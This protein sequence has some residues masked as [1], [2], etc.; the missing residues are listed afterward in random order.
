MLDACWVGTPGALGCLPAVGL[1]LKSD[2]GKVSVASVN[3]PLH[4]RRF[5][6]HGWFGRGK[7]GNGRLQI[8]DGFYGSG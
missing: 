6:G 2:A 5:H 8:L 3:S 1:E 4:S 7:H